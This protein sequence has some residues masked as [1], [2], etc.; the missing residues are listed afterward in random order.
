MS[1]NYLIETY[2]L[3]NQRLEEFEHTMLDSKT[4]E[5]ARQF[6]AGRVQ[7]LCD[8]ERFIRQKFQPKLPRRLKHILT[9]Q[10]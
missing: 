4:D 3:I 7:A 9:R 6:A 5:T 1:H 10:N 8:I 2:N